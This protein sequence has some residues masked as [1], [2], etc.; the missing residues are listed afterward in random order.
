MKIKKEVK[1]ILSILVILVLISII[2]ARVILAADIDSLQDEQQ[3]IKDEISDTEEQLD[4]IQE[5]LSGTMEE[6][7]SLINQI[8]EY[9]SEIDDLDAQIE[10]ITESIEEAEKQIE[11]S[12]KELEEKQDLL[13]KRLIA[14]YKSGDSSYLDVLLGSENI[15]DFISNYY[16]VEELADYDT[17]LI[18]SVEATKNE[19][20]ASKIALE[21]NKEEVEDLKA[22][23]VAKKNSLDVLKKDKEAKA[24]N[25]TEDEQQ[26]KQQLEELAEENRSLDQEIRAAQQAIQDA[27]E[28]H[29]NSGGSS[30]SGFIMPVN[31]YGITT[32]LYYSSGAYHGA[33]DFSGSGI[34]GTPVYAVADG[35]VVT[36][37]ALNYSY[38]NYV[39]IAH[40]NGLY[41]LYA[42]GQ[43]GSIC[44][45]EGQTVK[46]GQQIMRVG[47][48]GNSTGPHLH[49]EVR[50]GGGTYS[51]RV[52]PYNY[53]P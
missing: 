25:L 24:A 13:N 45:S 2:G 37:K 42:H 30:S 19:I 48:T 8:S 46:Q 40:Y 15:V 6:I 43:M 32:G 52:N 53:L 47:S 23:Q 11:K 9:E 38:G 50:T 49:F 29:I 20:E 26:L 28:D 4:G 18:E 44:V 35:Y 33:V 27:K 3:S 5:E 7:D 39:L 1:I 12:E 51:E 17:K 31:G 34:S 41:T 21:E 10:E 22:K 16:L 14:V 36:A